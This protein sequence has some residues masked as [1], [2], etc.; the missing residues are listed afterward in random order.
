MRVG[1]E[2]KG[3]GGGGQRREEVRVCMD[4]EGEGEGRYG[5]RGG[6]GGGEGRYGQRKGGLLKTIL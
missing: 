6:G 5:K 4:K 1:R 2:K 3:G